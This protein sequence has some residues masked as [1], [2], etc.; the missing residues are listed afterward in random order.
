MVLWAGKFRTEPF[1]S[2]PFG[3]PALYFAEKQTKNP[4]KQGK[5]LIKIFSVLWGILLTRGGS[6]AM[7]NQR[8][9]RRSFFLC[10]KLLK[11]EQQKQGR[12]EEAAADP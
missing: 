7:I 4:E 2:N 1:L 12:N 5:T 9:G 10:L 8:H 6:Y 3:T 11:Y